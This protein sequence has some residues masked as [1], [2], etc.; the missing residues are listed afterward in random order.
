[1]VERKV[2]VRD[3]KLTAWQ[4]IYYPEVIRGLWVTATHFFRNFTRH[5]A[6]YVFRMKSVTPG[7]VT[8]QY[9][10]ER[11]PVS[12]RWRGRHRLMLRPDGTP[13]CVACMM[14]ESAC[15]DECIYITAAET[16]DGRIEKYPVT[17][18]IDLLRC[19]FCGLCVEACPEDAIRMDTFD[20]A[21][22]GYSRKD[23]FLDREFLL[24]GSEL[25][26]HPQYEGELGESS[27]T[28]SDF[29]KEIL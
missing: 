20:L 11:R 3:V 13:R 23:F 24:R 22:A 5:W 17:F 28:H 10:E 9:P 18:D 8:I 4:K 1:M 27:R 2:I 19:C 29:G 6:R 25:T 12:P 14:C 7:A 15:P 21:L 16:P 26:T